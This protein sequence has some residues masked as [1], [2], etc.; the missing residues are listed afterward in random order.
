MRGLA[1]EE[2]ITPWVELD[3]I[4]VRTVPLDGGARGNEPE[5]WLEN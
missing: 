3:G 4:G 5:E 2:G 1:V